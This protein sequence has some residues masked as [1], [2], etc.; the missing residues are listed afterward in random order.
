MT[1]APYNRA[2]SAILRLMT[3]LVGRIAGKLA[4]TAA[5]RQGIVEQ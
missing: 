1:V 3:N 4:G 5:R 2:R